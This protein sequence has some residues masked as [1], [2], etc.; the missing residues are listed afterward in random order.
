MNSRSGAYKKKEGIALYIG[1]G[2]PGVQ[3]MLPFSDAARLTEN[4]TLMP[5]ADTKGKY[6]PIVQ[7]WDLRL[8]P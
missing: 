4:Y 6:G 7:E 2:G 5:T 3:T 1:T 8:S